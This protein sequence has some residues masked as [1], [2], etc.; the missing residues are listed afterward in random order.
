MIVPSK[1][2]LMK[3]TLPEQQH[4]STL[5]SHSSGMRVE[6]INWMGND[7]D[8]I[9]AARVSLGKQSQYEKWY[10]NH[11][12]GL[13]QPEPI[14]YGSP[15][16]AQWRPML[17]VPDDGLLG[18][19]MRERHGTPFEMVQ[20]QFRVRAPIGVVWE[21]VRHR[22]ASYN[23]MSTRYVEWDV[24]YYVPMAEEWR[25]QVGKVGHYTFEQM[26]EASAHECFKAYVAAMES[27]F[28]YYG[29]LIEKG[30]AKEVARNVLPMGAMTEFIWSINARSM[31]NFLSLRNE[32]HAL[33][34]MQICAG[35]VEDLTGLIIPATLEKWNERERV[36]P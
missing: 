24:D 2:V 35:M 36:A 26:D 8:I 23:V 5:R 22:I 18:Y 12:S 11:T 28:D 16:T 9:N 17:S 33:K 30:L 1:P 34:E 6:L 3:Q 27:A 21:W 25:T 4:I 20:L 19:L 10:Y 7:I 15:P 32:K 31:L 13:Y 14:Y 29:I